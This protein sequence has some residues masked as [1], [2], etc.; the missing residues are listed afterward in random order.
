MYHGEEGPE[1]IDNTCEWRA[2]VG[3]AKT[4]EG[5]RLRSGWVGSGGFGWELSFFY[6]QSERSEWCRK[7]RVGWSGVV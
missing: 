6:M 4:G 7:R 5:T 3:E 2:G 1:I